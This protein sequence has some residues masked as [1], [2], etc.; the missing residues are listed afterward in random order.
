VESHGTGRAG[1]ADSAGLTKALLLKLDGKDV[2]RC[3]ECGIWAEAGPYVVQFCN[4]CGSWFRAWHSR[5]SPAGPRWH[6]NTEL[7]DAAEIT[8]TIQKLSERAK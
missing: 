2:T 4:D 8:L 1:E 7:N 3:A 6:A 5:P